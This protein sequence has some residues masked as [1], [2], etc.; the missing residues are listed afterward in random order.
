LSGAQKEEYA[1]IIDKPVVRKM[2]MKRIAGLRLT[3]IAAAVFFFF[4]SGR[5][6][7]DPVSDINWKAV[8]QF[9][10]Q[11]SAD[12]LVY[13]KKSAFGLYVVG[14]DYAVL[15]AARCSIGMNPD[16]KPKLYIADNRTP[17]GLY[18][19]VEALRQD[20]PKT[21]SG[22]RKLRDM[23][24]VL[25]RAVNGH[26]KWADP[27]KDLGTNVYG[28]GFFLL[29]YPNEAD[30]K[31]YIEA[32][33]N[34][35]IPKDRLKNFLSQGGG[36]AIHGTNDPESIGHTASNG[37]VRLLNEDLRAVADWLEPGSCVYIDY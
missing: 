1:G 31:K 3:V 25:F 14:R 21:S 29:N 30:R 8:K 6:M 32:M 36:I 28:F 4:Y 37:C 12:H 16:L 26:S 22:Y 7:C 20:L 35:L 18:K 17:E 24:S 33:H 11:H 27:K 23:N 13:V 5:I 9:F 10:G 19:V 2:D 34:G 15:Y